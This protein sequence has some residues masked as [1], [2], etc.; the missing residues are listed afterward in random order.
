MA[1]KGVVD[2]DIIAGN[3]Y[4]LTVDNVEIFCVSISS[5]E[6]SMQVVEL[7]DGTSASGGRTEGGIECSV[8]IPAHHVDD[9]AYMDAWW[10]SGKDPVPL[11][12]YKVVTLQGRSKSGSK[13]MTDTCLGVFIKGRAG[14]EYMLEDGG[15]TM[16]VIEYTLSIDDVEHSQ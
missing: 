12:A 13:V 10:N 9:I 7:P 3:E 15:T 4:T 16:T 11:S 5:V 14:A 2:K 1:I 6:E 8:S